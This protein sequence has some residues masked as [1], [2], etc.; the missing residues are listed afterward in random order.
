M[1]LV[2]KGTYGSDPLPGDGECV[3]CTKRAQTAEP[4]QLPT[5]W[6]A[7]VEDFERGE[8]ALLGQALSRFC[9]FCLIELA[10]REICPGIAVARQPPAAAGQVTCPD[11]TSGQSSAGWELMRQLERSRKRVFV[12]VTNYPIN[13]YVDGDR[14]IIWSPWACSDE[15]CGLGRPVSHPA[16]AILAHELI[17]ALHHL[18][19]E[20]R[21]GS[22]NW[23]GD[24]WSGVRPAEEACTVCCEN[25]IRAGLD[26]PGRNSYEAEGHWLCDLGCGPDRVTYTYRDDETG[27]SW[28][29][30]R[31]RCSGFESED[32]QVGELWNILKRGSLDH[33]SERVLEASAPDEPPSGG[34]EDTGFEDLLQ[35]RGTEDLLPHSWHLTRRPIG[36]VS[37]QEPEPSAPYEL[38]P[39]WAEQSGFGSLLQ[40]RIAEDLHVGGWLKKLVRRQELLA[41]RI[42]R[43]FHTREGDGL[44]AARA[45]G[46]DVGGIEARVET[47]LAHGGYSSL[48][49]FLPGGEARPSLTLMGRG[50]A[51]GGARDRDGGPVDLP[52]DGDFPGL[53]DQI[54]AWVGDGPSP[55][56]SGNPRILDGAAHFLSAKVLTQQGEDERLGFTSDILG[57]DGRQLAPAT[58]VIRAILE[59]AQAGR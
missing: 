21:G 57:S 48:R 4:V 12:T 1:P 6:S 3:L 23:P 43:R 51:V 20:A 30:R 15:V 47:V 32:T 42:G 22:G 18:Q 36:P 19:W 5:S 7:Y 54:Q 28:R 35:V 56:L 50:W 38:P 46:R 40:A 9:G 37:G 33:L 59:L 8:Q 49:L 31:S 26:Y 10:L 44:A 24:D 14:Q 45:E 29:R 52:I 55:D 17:H 25:Q 53:R 41:D 11:Q 27:G 13:R 16:V 2:I 58:Q 34:S 39:D